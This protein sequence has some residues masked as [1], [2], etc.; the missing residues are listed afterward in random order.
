MN[1]TNTR[2]GVKRLM[3]GGG[4]RR[5]DEPPLGGGEKEKMEVLM[6]E[7]RNCCPFASG[8]ATQKRP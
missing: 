2:A 8:G 5:N 6:V 4:T 1:G 3:G 7:G